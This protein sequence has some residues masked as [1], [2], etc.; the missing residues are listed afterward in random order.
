MGVSNALDT[1]TVKHIS[2]GS[3][4]IYFKS[5]DQGRAKWQG[6]TLDGVWLDEEPP[7]DLYMEA[8]TRTNVGAGPIWIT[9][10]PLLGMSEVVRLFLAEGAP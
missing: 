7:L 3:S 4:T 2:G 8:I 10:T 1:V 5:Y 6:P 9:F